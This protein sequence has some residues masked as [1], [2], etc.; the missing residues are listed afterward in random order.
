MNIPR[1][2]TIYE[3]NTAVFLS[4]A[5]QAANKPIDFSS[6][7]DEI[8]DEIGKLPIDA[9]WF[10]G[11][12]QRSPEA[13]KLAKENPELKKT[14]PDLKD[15]DIL[16]SAYSIHKYEVDARFGGNA[17]LE[18]ARNKLAERGIGL[19]LDYVPNHVAID[20]PWTD[21]HLDYF[22]EGMPEELAKDPGAFVRRPAGII[23]K[24]KDPNF[25][26]W[27]DV[28]QLNAFSPTLRAATAQTLTG[29]SSMCD[30]VR[31]DMA[32]LMMNEVFAK[33]WGTRAGAV[34]ATDY[35]ATI[36]PEVRENS[37]DFL[38]IAEVYWNKEEAL[39]KQGFDL[40]YDKE[41]YDNLVSGSGATVKKHLKQRKDYQKHQLRF[42]EN[43]DEPRAASVFPAAQQM[44]AATV[45][46]TLSGGRLYHEGQ[47]DGLK[48]RVP[49]HLARR[50]QEQRDHSLHQ[51]YVDLLKTVKEMQLEGGHWQACSF[52]KPW[53][54]RPVK[55]VLAWHWQTNAGDFVV[56]VNYSPN[57][58]R[59]RLKFPRSL[60]LRGTSGVDL[61]DKVIQPNDIPKVLKKKV[62][63]LAAWSYRV[64]QVSR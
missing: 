10:M 61:L 58:V 48:V 18:I 24:G 25:A 4:E 54:R 31:C 51:F 27:S 13:V 56:L 34:P 6:V 32:M 57:E 21:N 36:I 49:V 59:G 11:V 39:L 15:Q 47:F 41:L 52:V 7:P 33:T 42:I 64:I 35:W 40:C 28:A 44:A 17:G 3:I 60:N 55:D 19:I 50:P 8:W 9:V 16:G 30:G 46:S 62:V 23:A 53:L 12:W 2:P 43:H 45:L 63:T 20:H 37:P 22:L 1:Q 29:I 14:L 38:F 26:P 5:G